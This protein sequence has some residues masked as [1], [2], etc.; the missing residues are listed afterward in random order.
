MENDISTDNIAP[1]P[2]VLHD[3]GEG[4]ATPLQHKNPT[5]EAAPEAPVQAKSASEAIKAAMAKVAAEPEDGGD[6]EVKA[7]KAE[8]KKPEPEP[9]KVT[10]KAEEVPA[11]K[12]AED[13]AGEDEAAKAAQSEGKADRVPSR[14]LPKAREVWWNTPGPVRAEFDRMEREASEASAKAQ[15]SV[16]FHESLRQY[17]DMAKAAG[18][19]VSDALGRYVEV[20][21][22]L[23]NDFGRGMAHIAQSHGKNPVEAVAQFMRSAGVLP[24]QLG[25]YLQGQPAQPQQ[26]QQQQRPQTVSGDPVAH[27]AMQRIQQLESQLQQQQEEAKFSKLETEIIA[28]FKAEN[29]RY[30]ELAEDIAFFLKSGK[31]PTSLSPVERLA[32]AYDMAE[33]INPAPI[34]AQGNLAE[35]ADNVASLAA[36]KSISGAPGKSSTSS[37]KP[38]IMSIRESLA[39]AM[40]TA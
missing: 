13:K 3:S 2:E 6:D 40:R 35:P 25:A 16:Q 7:V 31:I 28:P 34:M 22:M 19:S 1:Q 12:K 20:D 9:E 37:G 39:A 24:Q 21:K 32:A 33:R 17:A 30:D 18:T 26:Q 11:D 15:E 23:A 38:K 29:H 5:K 27:Q 36:K 10:E 14:L 4:S 8:E